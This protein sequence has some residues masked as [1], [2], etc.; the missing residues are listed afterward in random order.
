MVREKALGYGRDQE[1]SSAYVICT[2]QMG[3]SGS[4][5]DMSMEIRGKRQARDTNDQLLGEQRM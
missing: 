4:Q 5:L 2:I 1:L 3:M